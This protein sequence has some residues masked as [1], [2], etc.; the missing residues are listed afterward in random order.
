MAESKFTYEGSDIIIQCNKNQKMKDICNNMSTKINVNIN[1]LV[2]L[3]GGGLLNLEK[4]FE[5]LTKENRISILVDKNEDEEICPKCGRLLKNE[6]INEIILSNNKINS[7]LKGIRRQIE[8]II[9]DI[10]NKVDIN[11]I[12]SQLENINVLINNINED[13]KKSNNK[14]NINKI[15]DNNIIKTNNNNKKEIQKNEI[16]CIY[17]KQKNKINLLYDYNRDISEWTEKEK[18]QYI[19]GKN[20]INENNIDIYIN[21]KKIKFNY[22]YK[23]NE[24]GNIKVKFIF[25]KLITST[26]CMFRE[27]SSLQSIDLSSFNNTNVKDMYRMYQ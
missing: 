23:S 14:L 27:C 9:N 4:T 8:L 18:K 15:N 16:I 7:S 10:N 26:C 1:S 13:I 6:I 11:D 21:D 5:E 17:N 12:I 22:K 20:N 19:E 24:K 2:F 25:N 3:Y